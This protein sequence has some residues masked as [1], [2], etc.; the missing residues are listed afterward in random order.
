MDFSHV[1]KHMNEQHRESLE[2]ILTKF[3]G[4]KDFSNVSLKSVDFS[5]LDIAY[6]Q[7]GKSEVARV[8]FP[9]TATQSTLKDAIVALAVS[10]R[11]EFDSSKIA[12][13][14]AE[15]KAEFDSVAIA[16]LDAN[17]KVVCSYAP[18]IQSK[19]GD[20][21]YI[22]QVAEHFSSICANPQNLEIMFLQDE[23]KAASPI[24]RKRLRYKASAEKIERE[25]ETFN[26]VFDEFE[27][28]IGSSRGV[29]QVR[30]MA[31]FQMFKLHLGTGR[32][33]FGFGQAYDI[34]GDKISP[35][36]LENPHKFPHKH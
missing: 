12:A 28:K 30:K 19:L 10:A 1:L 34:N 11:G 20:F 3:A 24:V 7:N 32:A 9:Q 2:N 18:I 33:V 15:F 35:A 17:G 16:S 27:A 8:D 25:S 22:S 5:G 13:K 36:Q 21:I 14:I 26:T 31:D 4:L 29:A 6:E 23:S